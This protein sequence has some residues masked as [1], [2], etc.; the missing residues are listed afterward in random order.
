M[1]RPSECPYRQQAKKALATWCMVSFA[2]GLIGAAGICA[3]LQFN[4]G[5]LVGERQTLS[6]P[7][8]LLAS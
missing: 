6:C 5:S 8:T 3:Y 7:S 2:S 1:A 4:S